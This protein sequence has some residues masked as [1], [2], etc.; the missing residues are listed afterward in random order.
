M[1][2]RQL[3]SN[4]ADLKALAERLAQCKEVTQF[5]EDKE[6]EAWTLAHAFADLE[7]SLRT[8]LEEQ[9]PRLTKGQLEASEIHA[10]LLEIGEEFRH[11]LYHIK[12]PKFYR[13]LHD[14]I[15]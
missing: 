5:D 3:L 9:L 6:C 10:L 4:G 7:E 1:S 13:Y 8:F 11:I 15:S 14:E 12:D 2:G